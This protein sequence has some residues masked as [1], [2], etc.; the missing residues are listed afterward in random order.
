MLFQASSHLKTGDETHLE[1]EEGGEEAILWTPAPV[2]RA[3]R[4]PALLR[5]P[6]VLRNLLSEEGRYVPQASY[7]HGF[8]AEI[9]PWMREKLA[10]WMLEVCEE[11]KCEEEVFPLAMNY[12]DRY[13]SCVPT[14]KNWLQLLGTVCMLLA[15][16][17]RETE[18]ECLVL[19]S[20]KWDLLSVIPNDF[21][22]YILQ[23]LPFS[24]QKADGVKKHA[25][26]F[27]A[28]CATDCTF[29]LYPPS[30][31]AVGSIAVAALG[32]STPTDLFSGDA[33]T[34][35]LAGIIGAEVDC[36]KVCQDSIEAAAVAK[37]LKQSSCPYQEPGLTAEM[38][39]KLA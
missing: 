21:L 19:R 13:L 6:R 23:Q 17:L 28:L 26:T 39:R 18:W 38:A 20:L 36:L 31:I 16:K 35:L 2:L 37:N 22:D 24:P 9:Q 10:F 1:E 15:S 30:L 25:Q 3:Q 12:V 7:F 5:H 33:I 29:I 4:D 8:Q 27:I 14:P 11:Q 34:E 32:F